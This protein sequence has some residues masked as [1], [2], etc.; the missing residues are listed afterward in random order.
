[1]MAAWSRSRTMALTCAMP[2]GR[3]RALTWRRG[4]RP[5]ATPQC[6]GLVEPE[7]DP[8]HRPPQ[9]DVA[10]RRQRARSRELEVER[11]A[12]VAAQVAGL[13]GDDHRPSLAQVAPLQRREGL[14][15]VGGEGPGQAQL[16]ASAVGALVTRQADLGADA[17]VGPALT[18]L[19]ERGG[20]PRLRGRRGAL[21][22]LQRLELRHQAAV[23]GG[24]LDADDRPLEGLE[25]V[26]RIEHVFYSTPSGPGVN[27]RTGACG[28]ACG[29]GLATASAR[30]RER[31]RTRPR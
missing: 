3:R 20:D 13:L 16:P 17:R 14:G 7:R 4:L 30:R 6:P 19:V 24:G 18:V 9:L 29:G 31:R 27:G 21:D 12:V 22:P 15:Q 2:L 28:R 25:V 1:M 23:V 5:F 10:E 11:A 8:L 26:G